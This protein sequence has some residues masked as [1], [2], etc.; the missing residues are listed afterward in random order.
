MLGTVTVITLFCIDAVISNTKLPCVI[1]SWPSPFL[2]LL[3][4]VAILTPSWA[5]YQFLTTFFSWVA[6]YPF[7]T[8]IAIGVVI[9]VYVVFAP[10]FISVIINL[11][12]ILVSYSPLLIVLDETNCVIP[13]TPVG[14]I[15]VIAT[16][17][18]L[19]VPLESAVVSV[20]LNWTPESGVLEPCDTFLRLIEYSLVSSFLFSI[21]TIILMNQ[22][23]ILH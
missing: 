17:V 1:V 18:C 9:L 2:I 19:F 21:F 3:L 10:R 20:A 22:H 16:G 7:W 11:S 13:S 6:S 14:S 23:Q 12:N 5:T 4:V 15:P 8:Y